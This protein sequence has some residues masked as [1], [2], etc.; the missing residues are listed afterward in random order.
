MISDQIKD[1]LIEQIIQ[2]LIEAIA[3]VTRNYFDFAFNKK[4]S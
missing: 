3:K 4:G 2:G 1:S